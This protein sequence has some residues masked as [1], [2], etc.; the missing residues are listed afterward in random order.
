M[1]R[2]VENFLKKLGKK[3]FAKWVFLDAKSFL[4]HQENPAFL[5]VGQ[6]TYVYAQGEER[7]HIWMRR[8][9]KSVG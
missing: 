9:V 4:G 8:G 7:V 2:L 1:L 5:Y 3:F 6:N